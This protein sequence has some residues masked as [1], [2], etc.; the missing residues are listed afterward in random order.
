MK[1]MFAA[2]ASSYGIDL[3]KV[4][5]TSETEKSYLITGRPEVEHLIGHVSYIPSR[6]PK[7]GG[8]CD[9]QLF[10]SGPEAARYLINHAG[11]RMGSLREQIARWERQTDLLRK[12]LADSNQ[13]LHEAGGE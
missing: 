4:T 5:I 13:P 1:K 12:L 7:D 3:G 2:H 11:K 6:V 10:K 8:A 9:V